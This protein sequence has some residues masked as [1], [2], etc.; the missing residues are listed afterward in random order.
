MQSEKSPL[1][2]LFLYL[3]SLAT[4]LLALAHPGQ[5]R[6]DQ[7]QSRSAGQVLYVPAYSHIYHG[8]KEK[9]LLLSV[10]LSI[11]NTDRDNSITFSVID[12]H[13]TAG[14][15]IRHYLEAPIELGPL[16]S[17]RYVVAE[18]DTSGGSGAN[19]VVE[20]KAKKP[21]NPPIAE[22]VMISTQSQLGISFTSRGVVIND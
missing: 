22:T 6:E 12:Y 7:A 3:F 20:W 19:F 18:R 10:T 11:R 16:G 14:K 1:I 2:R 9:P 4:L 21:V 15:L 17:T 13:D 8:N 5:A